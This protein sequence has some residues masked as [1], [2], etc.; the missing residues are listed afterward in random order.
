M[1]PREVVINLHL[2]FISLFSEIFGIS[3]K[4]ISLGSIFFNVISMFNIILFCKLKNFL[5]SS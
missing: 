5:S 4:F 2:I 3:I 1:M